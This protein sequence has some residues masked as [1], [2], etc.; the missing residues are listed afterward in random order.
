MVD[1]EGEAPVVS[2]EES[3]GGFAPACV[4][5]GEDDDGEFEALCLMDGHEADDVFLFAGDG[6]LLLAGFVDD[7]L[8]GLAE[9]LGEGQGLPAVPTSRA[10]AMRRRTLPTIRLP[11]NWARRTA[12]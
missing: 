11:W 4:E 7:L 5:V 10:W 3:G 9:V 1:A 6:G 8:G 12:L 2:G